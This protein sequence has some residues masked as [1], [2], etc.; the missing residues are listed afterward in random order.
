MNAK[1]VL[2]AI[3]RIPLRQIALV[4]AAALPFLASLGFCSVQRTPRKPT[5]TVDRPALVFDQYFVNLSDLHNTARVEALYHFKNTAKTPVRITNLEPSCGCLNPKVEKREY[6]PGE[7]CDFSLGVLMTREK[8]GP[9]DYFLR[10]DYQDPKPRSVTVAF[11]VVVRQEVTVRPQALMFFQSGTEGA[12]AQTIVVSDMRPK[13]LRVTGGTCES[14][15]VK[16]QV[17]PATDDPDAGRETIV[18][19]SVEGQVPK[20]GVKTAVILSTDDPHYPK[21]PIL[22]WISDMHGS[23]IQK[24]SATSVGTSGQGH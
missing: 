24:T 17:G 13:P 6:L 3:R 5:G 8:P 14:R 19:V 20:T 12:P 4:A 21:I 18:Y 23:S 7:E 22:I 9:H 10:I 16:F 1:I 2:V 15:L 11:K